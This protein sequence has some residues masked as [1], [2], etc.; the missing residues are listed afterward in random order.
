MVF[1]NLTK[2][3]FSGLLW[4]KWLQV[5]DQE[6]RAKGKKILLLIDNCLGHPAVKKNFPPNMTSVLWPA[7]AGLIHATK[8]HYQCCLSQKMIDFMESKGSCNNKKPSAQDM[9]K[10]VS[11]AGF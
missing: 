5:L 11:L 7:D 6:L 10:K 4:E 8:A 9:A 2:I 3:G 1:K